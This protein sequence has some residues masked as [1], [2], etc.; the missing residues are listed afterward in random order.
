MALQSFF[1]QPLTSSMLMTF[2]ACELKGVRSYIQHLRDVGDAP[3]THLVAGG[4]FAKGLEVA[5]KAYY[6]DKE[7]ETDAEILGT[8]ALIDYY[9]DHQPTRKTKSLDNMIAALD[10]YFGEYPLSCMGDAPIRLPSGKHAIEHSFL[11]ELPFKHPD[12]KEETPLLIAGRAD[13]IIEHGGK[14]W[15]L[16]EKT[17]GMQFGR[18]WASSW[19]TRGQFTTYSLYFKRQGLD[20]AGVCVRGVYLGSS[21]IDFQECYSSR[22]SWQLEIWEKQLHKKIARW[23]QQYKDWK[24]SGGAP[25]GEFFDGA[26]NEAC[27]A[28]F[29]TCAFQDF[30]LYKNF[31]A[32]T[33]ASEQVFWRPMH[34]DYL[35]LEDYLEILTEEGKL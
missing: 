34:Q 7:T 11:A 32:S 15:L 20:I 4:A 25:V 19:A 28:Y 1:P 22:S 21:R 33:S 14:L 9:G 8:Q 24:N 16:D 13:A 30:C 6:D 29:S 17:T 12:L 5:R 26:W 23:L 2:D 3:S 18:N 27:N 10:L 31:E 35:P